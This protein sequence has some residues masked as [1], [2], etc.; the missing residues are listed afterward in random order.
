ML[1]NMERLTLYIYEED[2]FFFITLMDNPNPIVCG[3]F[4]REEMEIKLEG[5]T[6]IQITKHTDP[7]YYTA[8]L[9]K[10]IRYEDGEWSN[11]V[12]SEE[13]TDIRIKYNQL[14]EAQNDR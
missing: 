2:N 4:G 3:F 13:I 8:Y 10:R 7:L 14:N 1:N 5:F 6:H 11:V 9:C 12:K